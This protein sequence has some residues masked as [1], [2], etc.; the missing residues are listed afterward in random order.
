MLVPI[1]LGADKTVV[2]VATGNQ[3]FHPLYASVGNVWNDVRRAHGEAVVPLAFLAVPKS[4]FLSSLTP[5]I[6]DL[7]DAS[8]VDFQR[9]EVRVIQRSFASSKSVYTTLRSL[10]SSHR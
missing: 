8:Y 4:E 3:E 1:I 9:L 5:L 10:R 2:S 6:I 7:N